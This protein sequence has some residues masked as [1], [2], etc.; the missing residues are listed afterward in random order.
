MPWG[1]ENR[2][3]NKIEQGRNRE[4]LGG[5]EETNNG[6]NEDERIKG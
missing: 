5:G 3:K 2:A 4:K 6:P 1:I